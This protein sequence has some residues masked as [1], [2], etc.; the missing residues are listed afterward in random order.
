MDEFVTLKKFNTY[1]EAAGVVEL[2]EKNKIVYQVEKSE[3]NGD[4]VFAGNTLNEELHVQ[5][6]SEDYEAAQRLMEEL[7]EVDIEK[8]DK[9]YY[10]FEFSDNEL[11]EI[12]EKPDE[13]SL[14]DYHWAQEILKQRGVL[15]DK[16]KLEQMKKERIQFLSKP[17]K[18]TGGYLSKAYLFCIFGGIV[19]FFMGKHLYGFRKL[20]PNGQKVIAFDEESRQKGKRIELIGLLSFLAYIIA[21]IILLSY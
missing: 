17:E 21:I 11:F 19:G 1:I 8:L 4:I 2:L 20:L 18:V 7:I 5:V 3:A 13:W 16:S 10:L 12:L 14:N 15:V 6:K 9:D